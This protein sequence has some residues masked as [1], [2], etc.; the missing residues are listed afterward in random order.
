MGDGGGPPEAWLR[1]RRI[2]L[3]A[4]F[5]FKCKCRFKFA[6]KFKADDRLHFSSRQASPGGALSH[7]PSREKQ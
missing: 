2:R 5:T 3:W 1:R 6:F 7:F 4:E